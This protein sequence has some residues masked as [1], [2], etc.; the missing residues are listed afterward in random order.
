MYMIVVF[1]RL[2]PD[3]YS[4]TRTLILNL[5]YGVRDLNN[6]TDMAIFLGLMKMGQAYT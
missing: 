1:G 2:Y 6:S 3:S 5:I 4:A